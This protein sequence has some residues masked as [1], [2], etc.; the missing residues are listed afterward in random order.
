VTSG[1]EPGSPSD[2]IADRVA[3]ALAAVLERAPRVLGELA[4][5]LGVGVA[6]LE[7]L[8]SALEHHGLVALDPDRTSV[9][10]GPAALHFARSDLGLADLVEL[11]RP[12]MRRLAAESGE[13]ANLIMPRPGGT[14]AIA[15]IDGT[16]LLGATNWVGRPLGLH[17]TAAGKVFMAH[18]VAAPPEGELE[19]HTPATIT[20]RDRLAAEL[21]TVRQNGYATI[22]D[23]LEPGL[24]AVAAPV[25]ERGAAV[26]AVLC[27]SGATLRLEPRRLEVLGRVTIEQA[28]E[29]SAL[30]GWE[31][32]DPWAR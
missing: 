13:T 26:I 20:D 2:A 6:E 16:H 31:D 23:E 17:A 32:P 3:H 28:D 5:E 18:G 29:I 12:Q 22:V 8:L 19:A 7:R 9:R 21:E 1:S 4:V 10:P 14:E 24:S 30:L 27:V 15:Q 25:R 11:A